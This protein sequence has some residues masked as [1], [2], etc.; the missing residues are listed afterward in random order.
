M[1]PTD[2]AAR[3]AG[4]WY[5]SMVLV[6]PFALMYIPS[7]TIVRGDAA[8][9]A[10][11]VL[12]HETLFRLGIVADLLG[13]VI[14]VGTALALY[15]LFAGVSQFRAAQMVTLAAISATFSLADTLNN[16]AALALFKGAEF[17]GPLDKVQREAL[18]M[19]F[20]RMHGQGI[21]LN[22]FFWGLWLL[23]FGLLVWRSGFLPR[24]LGAWLVVNCFAYVT[25]SFIGL[26]APQFANA[27][28]LYA[29]PALFGELAIMLW[30]LFKGAKP[31]IASQALPAVAPA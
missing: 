11:K 14:F 22:E 23:P 5:I 9:T 15:R 18:G 3:V 17:L 25:L 27:A 29:Q 31:R 1:H 20:I 19:F 16:V 4:A 28:F 13:A 8:A 30:L 6:G 21:V 2:K 26:F 12:E 10:A 7:K 24:F